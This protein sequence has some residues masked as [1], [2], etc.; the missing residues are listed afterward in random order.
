MR[1][2]RLS[3]VL[4]DQITNR[5]RGAEVC[6][7]E[8]VIGHG[9][10]HRITFGKQALDFIDPAAQLCQIRATG[11]GL[12][13]ALDAMEQRRRL[14]FEIDANRVGRLL[15]GLAGPV[16]H[17]CAPAESDHLVTATDQLRGDLD[18][19]ASPL[20]LAVLIEDIGNR[21]GSEPLA[22]LVVDVD[23]RLPQ[24]IGQFF[25]QRGLAAAAISDQDD[26]HD[27]IVAAVGQSRV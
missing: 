9:F 25:A 1:R 14:A 7:V 13:V 24:I 3:Q 4:P 15:D 8:H 19:G 20:H 12:R 2:Q 27:G 16:L 11:D 6:Y 26:I 23:E 21:R 10:V 18:F 22:R 17:E 5:V